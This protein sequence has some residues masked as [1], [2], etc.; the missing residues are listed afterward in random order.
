MEIKV[1]KDPKSREKTTGGLTLPQWLSLATIIIFIIFDAL[2][3]IYAF[4]PSGLLKI[5]MFI[6]IAL[7]VGNALYRP[8]G[9]KFMTWLKL[10]YRFNITTQT[11]IYQKERMKKYSKNDF[12]KTKKIK[13]S[14]F[15]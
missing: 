13:E 5:T 1:F 8:H 9:M 7:A 4:V 12:K 14:D 10:Y 3:S 15:K 6:F 2:N 11:R